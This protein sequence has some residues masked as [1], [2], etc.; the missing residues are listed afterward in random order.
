M[1][2]KHKKSKIIQPKALTLEEEIELLRKENAILRKE[3][4][5]KRASEFYK[6]KRERLPQ[7]GEQMLPG[8]EGLDKTEVLVEEEVVESES[9]PVTNKRKKQRKF[10]DYTK[11]LEVVEKLIDLTDGEKKGMLEIAEDS[12]DRLAVIPAKY[13]IER[14]IVKRYVFENHPTAGVVTGFRP[15]NAIPGSFFASSFYSEVLVKKYADHLPLYR[16]EEQLLRQGLPISRQTL[17]K[18]VLKLAEVL[19]PLAKLLKQTILDSKNVFMDETTVKMQ[20]KGVCKQAYFWLLSGADKNQRS[21]ISD[22]PLVFYEFHDN[23]RHENVKNILGEKYKGS[24]HSD[25]YEAYENF[26][27]KEGVIWQVC[28]AHARRKFFESKEQSKFRKEIL[29]LMDQLFEKEREYWK[30]FKKEENETTLLQ[31]RAKNCEPLTKKIFDKIEDFLTH[32][33]YLKDSSILKACNYIFYRKE[34]FCN[35]LTHPQ[36][37]IDNN[38]SERKIRPLTIGRKN[39]LFVGNERGGEAAATIYSLIQTCRNLKV[40]PQAY[41]EDVLNQINNI[42]KSE[43]PNLLPHNWQKTR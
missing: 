14:T 29:K 19:S 37:R 17:S 20:Q 28:W 9:K 4:A 22:P 2:K 39:W 40:D 23:R 5:I 35:F 13:Y 24:L 36:M 25:A 41:L 7:E 30:L 26:A 10:K 38:V 34:S 15:K 12:Y 6:S 16:I 18:M 11:H 3:L 27:Q 42:E 8:F 33:K 31:F 43:L 1:G 21:Q 32:G